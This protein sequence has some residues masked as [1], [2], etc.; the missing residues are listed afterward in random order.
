MDT[1]RQRRPRLC[2][3]SRGNNVRFILLFIIPIMHRA[4]L[5]IAVHG[6]QPRRKKKERKE[7]KIVH[8]CQIMQYCVT[9]Q[10]SVQVKQWCVCV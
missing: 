10:Y 2:I 4:Q 7:K 9:M 5:S 8:D 1:T 3:A 6:D